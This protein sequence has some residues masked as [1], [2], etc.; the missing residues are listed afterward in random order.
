MKLIFF[1]S[2]AR[3]EHDTIQA[4]RDLQRGQR[5]AEDLSGSV[6]MMSGLWRLRE[7]AGQISCNNGST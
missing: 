6:W 2:S 1:H 5:D 7:A 4:M 3:A